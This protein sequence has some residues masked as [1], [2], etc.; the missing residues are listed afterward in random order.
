VPRSIS[1]P[2]LRH[3]SHP[4]SIFFQLWCSRRR[5]RLLSLARC[6]FFLVP[7][8][9][10]FQLAGHLL[11]LGAPCSASDDCRPSPRRGRF[12]GPLGSSHRLPRHPLSSRSWNLRALKHQ[13]R[14]PPC[15]LFSSSLWS[16]APSSRRTPSSPARLLSRLPDPRPARRRFPTPV[17]AALTPRILV[18]NLQSSPV[19]N[20]EIASVSCSP[21]FGR[22]MFVAARSLC[23]RTPSRFCLIGARQI[24][25]GTSNL[26]IV[27]DCG[28]FRVYLIAVSTCRLYSICFT[29]KFIM[30]S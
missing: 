23:H 3:P 26:I 25:D 30:V 16:R 13:P 28:D 18:V 21:S 9:E 1:F 17:A 24:F 22:E 15:L 2:Q 27:A 29:S 19:A 14:R 20:M 11:L 4:A 10:L 8:R 12:A 7:V 6:S 5:P